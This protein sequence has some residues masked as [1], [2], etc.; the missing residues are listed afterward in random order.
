MVIRAPF[1]WISLK[2]ASDLSDSPATT[3]I[4]TTVLT[5]GLNHRVN[6]RFAI[7]MCKSEG[8]KK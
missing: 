7:R 5:S 1:A 2:V 3:S 8:G 6:V 4:T